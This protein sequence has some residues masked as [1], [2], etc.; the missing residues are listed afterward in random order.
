MTNRERLAILTIFVSVLGYSFVSALRP[1]I[2]EYIY[3]PTNLAS[4]YSINN[5]TVISDSIHYYSNEEIES[6]MVNMLSEVLGIEKDDISLALE[7]GTTP[8]ELL[9]SEGILL[10]DL[11]EAYSFD[12]V[13]EKLVKFRA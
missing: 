12:I 11:S 10:S 13:G 1:A 4:V 6:K 7:G 3:H 5:S 2:N 9:A 8:S